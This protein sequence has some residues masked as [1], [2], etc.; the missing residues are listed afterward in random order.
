MVEWTISICGIVGIIGW[1]DSTAQPCSNL[2]IGYPY[3]SDDDRR[4]GS[5][6]LYW[7][8]GNITHHL[9]ISSE[10]GAH[11]GLNRGK[12]GELLYKD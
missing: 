12:V 9:T 6:Y 7:S 3:L 5:P 1:V 4:L 2:E 11:L 8:T 10:L